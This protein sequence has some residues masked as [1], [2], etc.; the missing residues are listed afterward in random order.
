MIR[1]RELNKWRDRR[2]ERE[3]AGGEG[4]DTCGIF[5]MPLPVR[6][7]I[8]LKCVAATGDG[9]EHVSVS[10]NLPRTPTW[11]EMEFVKRTF[12]KPDEVAMQLHVGTANHIS[13]HPYV[14]HIWRPENGVIPL[15]PS[16]MV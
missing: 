15:P 6:P 9:W 4:D 5:L 2:S 13:D 7:A 8:V 1:L 12:F 11:G 3:W 14:L 10:P 16:W